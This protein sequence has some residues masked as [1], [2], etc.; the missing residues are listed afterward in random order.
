MG[1]STI[2][3]R[4]SAHLFCKHIDLDKYIETLHNL[5]VEEIFT[6]HGEA[7]FRKMEEQALARLLE[8]NKEKILVLSLGGG[9]LISQKN[10]VLIKEKTTCIYLKAGVETLCQRLL[11]SRKARPLVVQESENDLRSK[12]H[13]LKEARE[14]GYVESASHIVLVDDLSIKEILI[15]ILKLI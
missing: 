11:K 3:E 7:Y 14:P 2:A 4:L 8:E 15:I 12:I 6:T 5:S 9:A 13:N 1:K 10:R